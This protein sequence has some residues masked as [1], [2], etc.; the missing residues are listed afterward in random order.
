MDFNLLKKKSPKESREYFLGLILKEKEG[1]LFVLEVNHEACTVRKIDERP[2]VFADQWEMAVDS[3][4]EALFQLE[5]DNNC[6][7]EKVIFFL[8]A[9]SI[10][11]EN[12]KIKKEYLAIVKTITKELELTPLGYIDYQEAI[13]L[14]FSEKEKHAL[15]ALI[16]EVDAA[17]LSLF[18]YKNG[19]L[20]FFESLPKSQQEGIIS[21]I[22]KLFA[23][24]KTKTVLPSRVFI[25]DSP[26]LAEELGDIVTH[27]WS[28][29]LFVQIPKFEIIAADR[30]VEALLFAFSQQLFEG[31]ESSVIETVSV[32]KP[33]HEVMG[34]VIGADIQ[35]K[36]ALKKEPV[37][38][39]PTLINRLSGS[40]ASLLTMV[41]FQ[42]RVLT[43]F[44]ALIIV[45]GAC[46]FS[47]LYFFHQSSV[48]ITL[49]SK[50][51]EKPLDIAGT[52]DGQSEKN[53]VSVKK[54]ERTVEKSDTVAATGK[55]IVGEKARGDVT[56]Y[57]SLKAEKVFKKNTILSSDRGVKFLLNDEVKVASASDSLTTDGNVLT[58]TG[59]A[60]G[61]LIADEIGTEGN[62]GKDEKLKIEDFATTSYFALP[63]SAFSGGTKRDVQTVSKDDLAKLKKA[64]MALMKQEAETIASETASGSKIID[65]LT[66]AQLKDE[67]YT[68]ELGEEAK[69]VS[70]TAKG[71][72]AVYTYSDEDIKKIIAD[73]SSDFIP[74][75][76]HLPPGNISYTITDAQLEDQKV[77]LSLS[78]GA[79][80]VM[81]LEEAQL[82]ADLKGKNIK[83]AEQIL[84]DTYKAADYRIEVRSFI[85]FLNSRLPFFIK[86]IK[87]IIKDNKKRQPRGL[88]IPLE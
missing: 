23:I 59:K 62:V 61:S 88:N 84:K 41:K 37:K 27:R 43:V 29:G 71:S 28:E 47:I 57:N 52:T 67:T 70:L 83:T 77:T 42:P 74:S 65:K 35:E 72:V 25:Y 33:P 55:K 24:L 45:I 60:K 22:N 18:V 81:K 7:L 73:R 75:G 50:T 58:V 3:I 19:L 51:I 21:D 69:N 78:V 5:R 2:V 64:I 54:I 80:A 12:K 4:D 6:T 86:N 30:L 53:A 44:V 9:K 66:I 79:R 20:S 63:V 48:T 15:T 40:F 17:V 1:C 38:T 46:A 34:F 82:L 36:P 85:P 11:Q 56:I 31:K 26:T 16:V 68:K 39:G 14:Y 87:L 10:D 49:Q 76:Y 13:A 32:E 8:Y